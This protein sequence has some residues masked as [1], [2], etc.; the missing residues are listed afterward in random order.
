M[1]FDYF[2]SN[3]GGSADNNRQNLLSNGWRPFQRDFDWV[4]FQQLIFNDTQELTQRSIN[5]VSFYADALARKDYAWWANIVNLASDYTRG[6]FQKFW[7]FITPDALNPDYRYKD[8]LTTEIPI[9]QLVNRN[10]IPIDY[11]LNLLQ[12]ITVLR[13]LRLLDRPDIITQYYSETD[14]YFPVE[15]FIS[16]ERLDIINTVYAYWSKYDIWLRKSF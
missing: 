8:I 9:I 1:D 13:I 2:R 3:D 4:Y 16:W 6:E 7:N 15:K 5:L 10:S 11:V 14:F 12:E